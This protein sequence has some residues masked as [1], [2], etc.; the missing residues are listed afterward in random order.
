MAVVNNIK[1]STESFVELDYFTKN[2]INIIT[3]DDDVGLIGGISF[4]DK[5]KCDNYI[6]NVFN[7]HKLYQPDINYIDKY[8]GIKSE[9]VLKDESRNYLYHIK[10]IESGI[11]IIIPGKFTLGF[12]IG[13][14]FY[15]KIYNKNPRKH[16]I[17][18]KLNYLPKNLLSNTFWRDAIIKYKSK[19]RKYGNDKNT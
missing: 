16:F 12:S 1:K 14:E 19:N 13:P 7:K 6:Q 3:K 11:W 17:Q 15:R 4:K 2:C 8:N 18:S 5:N 10:E 9:I